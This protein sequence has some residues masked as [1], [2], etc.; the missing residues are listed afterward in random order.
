MDNLNRLLRCEQQ[1][2][3]H[4]QLA[5]SLNPGIAGETA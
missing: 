3:L 4:A 2:A 5:S 1:T